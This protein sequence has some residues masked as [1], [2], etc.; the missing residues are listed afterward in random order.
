[1][2]PRN[3]VTLRNQVTFDL[4]SPLGSTNDNVPSHSKR[5]HRVRSRPRSATERQ[6]S[7]LASTK[8]KWHSA[9]KTEERGMKLTAQQSHF[10]NWFWPISRTLSKTSTKWRLNAEG[11]GFLEFDRSE[12]FL[13]FCLNRSTSQWP[14]KGSKLPPWR[15][16]Y[17]GRTLPNTTADLILIVLNFLGYSL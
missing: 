4:Y 13:P 12:R 1:M 17:V 16:R 2:K 8:T 6:I 11:S 15:S 3:I 14:I 5:G 10:M 7:L 9:R